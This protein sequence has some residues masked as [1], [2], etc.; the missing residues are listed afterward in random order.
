MSIKPTNYPDLSG[1]R[2]V[3]AGGTGSVGE[4][5]VRGY[6]RAGA[7]VIVPTRSEA[8]RDEFIE[9]LEEEGDTERLHLLVADYSTFEGARNLAERVENEVGTATDVAGSIGGWHGGQAIWETTSEA[10]AEYFVSF[11]TAHLALAQAFLPRMDANGAYHMIAGASGIYPVQGSGI[12]SMQ[13]AA[14]LMQGR[15]LQAETGDQRRVFTELLGYVNTR[16]RPGHDP[17]NISAEDVGLLTTIV[18]ANPSVTSENYQLL[19]Q[20]AFQQTLAQVRA[21]GAA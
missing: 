6:L 13:Q 9:V 21:S 5:I 20:A 4:G 3:V 8:R 14:L 11:A 18:S 16:N 1:R 10:W 2:V 17:R 19:D 12:V 15:V 7:D